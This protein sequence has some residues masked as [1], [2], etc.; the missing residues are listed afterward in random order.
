MSLRWGIFLLCSLLEIANYGNGLL[1]FA[2]I[3]RLQK[4]NQNRQPQPA[5]LSSKSY[6]LEA[7]TRS[8]SQVQSHSL[9]LLRQPLS[10]GQSQP[11]IK[12]SMRFG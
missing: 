1:Y 5:T 6:P 8:A 3:D 12:A 2:I 7:A 10:V 11:L 9:A 4:S